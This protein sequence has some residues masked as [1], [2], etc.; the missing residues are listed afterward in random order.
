MLHA[1]ATT[2]VDRDSRGDEPLLPRRSRCLAFATIIAL[3]SAVS[4]FAFG[5]E[6]GIIDGVLAMP[7]FRLFFSTATLSG[8]D[9]LAIIESDGAADTA[10]WIVS[11][12]LL[13]AMIGSALAAFSADAFGRRASILLGGAFFAGGGA[14]QAAS[15]GLASLLSGRILSGIG[16]GLMS[17]VSPLFIAETAAP[18]NRGTL[19]AGQQLAITIGIFCASTVNAII[20]GLSSAA[21]G[22]RDDAQWRAALAAQIIPGILVVILVARLPESP[23]WL[24][25]NGRA[26]DAATVLAAL[27]EKLAD[28]SDVAAEVAGIV[29]ELEGEGFA[30]PDLGDAGGVAPG[31]GE[32]DALAATGRVSRAV[33]CR[34][35]CVSLRGRLRE[36]CSA[37]DARRRATLVVGL[38]IWQ[39]LT[40]INVIL[41][42][43]ADLMERAGAAS[44]EQAATT[45]V[46]AN[47]ALLI[48]GTVPGMAL[49][50]RV[51][52][53]R[54]GLLIYG[55]CAMAAAHIAIATAVLAGA[56]APTPALA[57][58]AVA[59]MMSF[60]VAFSATWG[61]TVWVFVAE[62][63]PLR[64]R[65]AGIAVGTLANW[66][67]NSM[68][69][70]F[71][72]LCVK[73]FGGWTYFGLAFFCVCMGLYSWALVPETA[74]R[75]LEDVALSLWGDVPARD[76]QRHD[77]NSDVS[78]EEETST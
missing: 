38:Q 34:G 26:R 25:A 63:L 42:Y 27:R 31:E 69:G 29:K 22:S 75:S 74:G 3:S 43:A 24:V 39:Q 16:V 67:V 62:A 55:A 49:L 60:T 45:L 36:L 48:I 65:G 35:H 23:R 46:V 71:A 59:A 66:S 77:G 19:V 13:G 44:R 18:A 70:K 7:S 17:S 56:R 37:G 54:R 30:P 57:Y 61:P 11:S 64:V 72:P 53:G 73:A 5:Y 78:V 9:G 68:I 33:S 14:L 41:Y 2:S 12:F 10:G 58:T 51:S 15:G 76:T 8:D 21:G 28:S 40:G 4:G 20:L 47:S 50:D 1:N 6:I 32:K 52:V